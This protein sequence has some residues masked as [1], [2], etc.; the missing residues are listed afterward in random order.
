MERITKEMSVQNVTPN[1]VM[2]RNSFYSVLL[3]NML[4]QTVTA[5]TS[6]PNSSNNSSPYTPMSERQQ[7]ALILDS[8]P[9]VLA[10]IERVMEST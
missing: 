5:V 7:M 1:K 3:I 8:V 6:S 10:R 9:P 4:M 2:S